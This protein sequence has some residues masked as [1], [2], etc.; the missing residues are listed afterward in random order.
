MMPFYR[1]D[2]YAYYRILSRLL[3]R[4]ALHPTKVV[5]H[6]RGVFRERLIRTL[7]CE[8][9]TDPIVLGSMCR[10]L[11][12]LMLLLLAMVDDDGSCPPYKTEMHYVNCLLYA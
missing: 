1:A 3:F 6:A 12:G 2:I 4:V 10:T 7:Y 5:S 8:G 9:T 11:G